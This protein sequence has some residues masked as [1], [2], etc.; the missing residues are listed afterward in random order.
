MA[1]VG[2]VASVG[3][4][5]TPPATPG[6]QVAL[7]SHAVKVVHVAFKGTYTG[8]IS[9]L[10]SSTGVQATAVKGTGTG[11]DGANAMSGSGSGSAASTCDPFSGLGALTGASGLKLQVVSSSKTQACAVN[12]AAP[13]PV[14]VKGVANVLS[15]TGKFKGATGTLSFTGTFSIQSTTAG[16][17]ESDSF[18]ATLTG[19]LTIK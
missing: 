12:S 14:T 13:T 9:L 11:T 1:T 3:A 2:S 15:G 4:V 8:T 17:S 19:T 16:S 6:A 10:W 5:V 18:N 7:T